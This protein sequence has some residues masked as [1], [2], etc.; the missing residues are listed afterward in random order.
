MTQHEATFTP[1]KVD[2]LIEAN[3]LEAQVHFIS[4]DRH[5]GK[6]TVRSLMVPEP[7]ITAAQSALEQHTGQLHEGQTDALPLWL[8]FFRY[9]RVGGPKPNGRYA[10]T[11]EQVGSLVVA[12]G[13]NEFATLETLEQEPELPHGLALWIDYF[14]LDRSKDSFGPRHPLPGPI[15]QLAATHGSIDGLSNYRQAEHTRDDDEAEILARYTLRIIEQAGQ[16]ARGIPFWETVSAQARTKLEK[17]ELD[18]QKA[19]PVASAA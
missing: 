16:A 17:I 14:R 10:V 8:D 19:A 4:P 1:P 18:R 3:A 11:K 2:D 12:T 13:L 15:Y 6:Y 7:T 5:L 9:E